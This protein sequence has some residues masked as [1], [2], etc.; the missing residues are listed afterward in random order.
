MILVASLPVTSMAVALLL[1][2]VSVKDW[3]F[4]VSLNHPVMREKSLPSPPM[5]R[6]R[7]LASELS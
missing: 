7:F 5:E 2:S 4:L 3:V 1:L 6:L